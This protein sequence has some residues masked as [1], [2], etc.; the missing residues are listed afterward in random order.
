MSSQ[1]GQLSNL[2]THLNLRSLRPAGTKT[3][4][5]PRGYGFNYV[6]CPNYFF[7]SIVWFAFTAL[8]MDYA[9]R[10]ARLFA[11]RRGRWRIRVATGT[12]Y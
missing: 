7:E 8:T 12:R 4:Q 9:G 6:S 10:S 3:R 5:I 2:V 11:S 1:F